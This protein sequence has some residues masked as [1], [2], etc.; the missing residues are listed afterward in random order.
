MGAGADVNIYKRAIILVMLFFVLDQQAAATKILIFGDFGSG[1]D[2][3]K[4]VARHMEQYCQQNGCDF[5]ITVGDNIYP[6]GVSNLDQGKISYDKGKPNYQIINNLFVKNYQSLKMP[7]YMSFGNHDVGNEGI[8]S[9]FADLFMSQQGI[10]KRTAQLML[11]QINYTTQEDNPIVLNNSGQPS[12]LWNFK[13][14]FYHVPEKEQVNLWAIDT[15]TYPHRAL[16]DDNHFDEHPKNFAQEQWLKESLQNTKGFK[17]VFGHMPLYSHGRHGYK[18]SSEIE[19]FRN[20]IIKLLCEQKVDFYLSGHDH[21][22]EVDR[23]VCDN[24]HEI[25]AVISGA[26]AKMDRVYHRAF[27]FFGESKNLIWANGKLYNNNKQIYNSEDKVLGFSYLTIDK[28]KVLLNMV[29]S[30]GAS[31]KRSN[32]CFHII[33][34][35]PIKAIACSQ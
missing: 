7:I 5:G 18:D 29:L 12:K 33:K 24:G 26:A 1:D 34:G 10:N 27:P 19:K 9:F 16:K 3:Q 8:K 15:N 22:L 17:I 11:N 30:Q 20:S 23:H 35:L 14:A 13:A 28:D 4:L 21:Q 2:N 25:T 31:A 32:G 6:A